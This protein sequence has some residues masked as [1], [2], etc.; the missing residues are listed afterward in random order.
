MLS[1]K[2]SGYLHSLHDVLKS[3]FSGEP[4]SFLPMAL[5][6]RR[7]RDASAGRMVCVSVVEATAAPP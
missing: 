5:K 6:A 2:K 7:V 3:S 4:P 1:R